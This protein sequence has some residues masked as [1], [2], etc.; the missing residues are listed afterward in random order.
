MG[1]GY[2]PSIV[3]DRLVIALDPANVKSYP[4]SGSTWYD[5]SGNDNHA[6]LFNSP[7]FSG[8][9]IELNGTNQY[10]QITANQT[11]LDFRYEQTI[12]V[13]EYHTFTSGRRNIWDQAYGGY[14]TWT[15]EQGSNINYYYG[16]AGV[17]NTPYTALGSTGT[18]TGIWN[19]MT[20]VRDVSNITFYN[21]TTG[22]SS[23]HSNS[24]ADQPVTSA[25]IRIGLGYT[26]V[27]WA[28]FMGPIFVYDKALTANEVLQNFNALRGRYAI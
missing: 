28:G 13:W 18:S 2:N 16:D 27:Y 5:I 26:G 23:T 14:G 11:S 21:S 15:H 22:A 1:I 3:K 6:T 8:G 25:N 17:N 9:T 12:M 24:Y 7:T 20:S 4:G 10:A 19:C